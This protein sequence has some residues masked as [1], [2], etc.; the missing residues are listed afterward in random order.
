MSL[1][2]SFLPVFLLLLLTT[3]T[4]ALQKPPPVVYYPAHP[5]GPVPVAVWLHGYRAFPS[6]L[7]DKEYFQRIADQLQVAIIGI[8]GTTLLDDGTAIWSE[9]SLRAACFFQI[10]MKLKQLGWYIGRPCSDD[11]D[12]AAIGETYQLVEREIHL[13]RPPESGQGIA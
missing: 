13:S 7:S 9:E 1:Y 6:I 10:G 11:P 3:A 12:G 2:R 8:P 5:I 4:Y